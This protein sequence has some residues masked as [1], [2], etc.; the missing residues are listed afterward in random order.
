VDPE[1]FR[2]ADLEHEAAFLVAVE[3]APRIDECRRF[4]ASPYGTAPASAL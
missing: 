4:R 1:V 2:L 3:P